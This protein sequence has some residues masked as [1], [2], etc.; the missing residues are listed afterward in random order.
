MILWDIEFPT[1]RILGSLGVPFIWQRKSY[2]GMSC[3]HW[4]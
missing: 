2:M 4:E 3:V 1:S